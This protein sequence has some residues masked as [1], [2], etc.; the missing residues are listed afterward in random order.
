MTA[1]RPYLIAAS[2]LVMTLAAIGRAGDTVATYRLTWIST[3]S[4]ETHPVDFPPNPHYSGI[5]G[6]THDVGVRFWELGGIASPGMETMSE[7][8]SKTLLTAEVQDA[9]ATGHA[10]QVLSGG[11]INP[12]PGSRTF[13]FT[14]DSPHPLVTIVSMIAP[15][16]DWFVGVD[17]LRLAQDGVWLDE[18]VVELHPYDTG[19]DSGTSYRS[20]NDDT[21]PQEPIRD[22]SHEFPFTGTPPL[23]TYTFTLVSVTG[24][25]ADFNDDGSVNTQDI[26]VFFNLWKADC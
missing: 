5:I 9:I 3:W 14:I 19:T 1:C 23:G 11:N 8:G 2:C 13:M 16:P 24:C 17:S 10:G 15:S 21:D 20:A 18:I 26:L 22:I 25:A 12:S 6:G 4:A 7:T